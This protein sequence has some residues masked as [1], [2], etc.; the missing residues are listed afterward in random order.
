MRDLSIWPNEEM[1]TNQKLNSITRLVVIMTLLGYLVTKT[2]KIM[3]TGI[4]TIV[5]II[6][7]FHVQQYKEKEQFTNSETLKEYTQPS[8]N[9]PCMNVMLHEIHENP[10]RPRAAYAY[11]ESISDKIDEM[12][13]QFITKDKDPDQIFNDLGDNFNFNQSMR[14]FHPMANTQIPND[15]KAFTDFCFGT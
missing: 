10:E 2:M 5:S 1:T 13:K 4:V 12:T 8:P 9:N 11:E 6:V 3:L 15:Q 7:L 14:A